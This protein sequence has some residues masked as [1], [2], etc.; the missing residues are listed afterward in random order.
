MPKGSRLGDLEELVL[1]A[2]LRLGGDAHGGRIREEL[3]VLADR[4]VSVGTIYVT[5]LRL[6][7]KG[8]ACSWKGEASASRGGTAKRHYDVSP[9]GLEALGAV[10]DTRERMWQGVEGSEANV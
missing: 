10:R 5:L 7:E 9:T 6:E 8:H 4:A 3:K 2:V 1:L